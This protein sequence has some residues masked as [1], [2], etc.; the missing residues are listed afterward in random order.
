MCGLAAD[1]REGSRSAAQRIVTAFE[2]L[3]FSK[4]WQALSEVPAFDAET[5][6]TVI[7]LGRAAYEHHTVD[8]GTAAETA[9]ARL[10]DRSAV[11]MRF[12][13]ALE[14]PVVDIAFDGKGQSGG[15]PDEKAPVAG[16]R[17]DQTD[18]NRL[19]LGQAVGENTPRR[20][21]ADDH[22][23]EFDVIGSHASMTSTPA[24]RI[25]LMV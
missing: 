24:A 13:L 9:A 15:H 18:F 22:I 16:T 25:F 5:A 21:R 6:P 23:V 19:V 20:S 1:H 2:S 17:F 12:R 4:K 7:V 3:H 14:F 8:G 10:A 11:Q